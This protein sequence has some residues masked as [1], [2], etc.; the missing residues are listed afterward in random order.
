MSI[1]QEDRDRFDA[2]AYRLHRTK[3]IRG[4][5]CGKVGCDECSV[6]FLVDFHKRA[7]SG[8]SVVRTIRSS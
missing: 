2:I 7:Q 6:K 8:L 3:N 1:T 4:C 5:E